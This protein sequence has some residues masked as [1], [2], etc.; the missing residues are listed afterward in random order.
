[1]STTVAHLQRIRLDLAYDGSDF[2]GWAEQPSLRTVEG[3][4]AEA[5]ATIVRH[6][7]RLSVAGRT[8]AGVHARGQVVH[9]D[10]PEED[11][12]RIAGRVQR[13][14]LDALRVRLMALLAR[15]SSGP[16]GSSDVVIT[17]IRRVSADFDARFSALSRTYTY[18]ICAEPSAIDP[19]RRRDVLWLA[20]PLDVESMNR[21]AVQLVGEHDYLSFCKP[22]DGATTIRTL[23]RLEAAQRD[24]II[25]VT[26]QADAF[27]HSMVRTLVGSLI[28]VGEGK[29]PESWPYVRL[30][31]RSRD[32]EVI[33]APPHPLTLE[34]VEYPEPHEYARRAMETRAVRSGCC[35]G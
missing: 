13:D 11:L 28:R 14:P 10:L 30:M 7:V 26:A 22:R 29:K 20:H 32:G 16:K 9:C 25:E 12:L 31:Q 15:G 21:A 2:H 4:V 24:G 23:M 19:L 34:R 6:E 5:L 3:V 27:C 17:G 35:G 1:M 8:D 18:R 33:V